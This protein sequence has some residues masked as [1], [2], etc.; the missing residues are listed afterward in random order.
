MKIKGSGPELGPPRGPVLQ[1]SSQ[2]LVEG[3]PLR[4]PALPGAGSSV[5]L[6]SPE[7]GRS[8]AWVCGSFLRAILSGKEEA[9]SSAKFRREGLQV[10]E[11]RT[12][13]QETGSKGL[14]KTHRSVGSTDGQLEVSHCV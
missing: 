14:R 10:G 11:E 3:L 13:P 5:R 4:S 9:T 8:L 1:V 7:V 6:R 12:R 2:V